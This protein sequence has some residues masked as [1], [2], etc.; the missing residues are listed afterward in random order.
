[1]TDDTAPRTSLPVAEVGNLVLVWRDKHADQPVDSIL[2]DPLRSAF[3]AIARVA[4]PFMDLSEAYHSDM[5]FDAENAAR[6]APDGEGYIG[7]RKW[8]TTWFRPDDSNMQD[9]SYLR[10]NGF[11]A[12]LKVVRSSRDIFFVSVTRTL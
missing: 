10:V 11:R 12:I 9:E 7:V 3:T 8:G 2:H 1:M 6:M 5:L 4:L